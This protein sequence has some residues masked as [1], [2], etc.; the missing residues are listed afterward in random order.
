M[1]IE[2]KRKPSF[3]KTGMKI[4]I[5]CTEDQEEYIKHCGCIACDDEICD[6]Q[7]G[8][9]CCFDTNNIVFERA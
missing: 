2:R 5:K 8:D 1:S 7:C 9:G 4:V 3:S 6:C